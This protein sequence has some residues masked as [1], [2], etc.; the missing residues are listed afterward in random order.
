MFYDFPKRKAA[1]TIVDKNIETR[2]IYDYD[3]NEI[4][5]IKSIFLRIV[6]ELFFKNFD[7]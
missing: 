2:L 7:Q 4:H 5:Q 1:I 6:I 3:T